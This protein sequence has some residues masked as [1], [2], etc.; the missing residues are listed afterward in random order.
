[1]SKEKFMNEKRPVKETCILSLSSSVGV[2]S[3]A[4]YFRTAVH[5]VGAFNW[6][7]HTGCAYTAGA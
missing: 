2:D 3:V 4:F 7:V 6:S 5:F 1:M